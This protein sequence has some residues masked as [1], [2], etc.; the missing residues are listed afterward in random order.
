[1][2]EEVGPDDAV[3]DDGGALEGGHAPQEEGALHEPVHGDPPDEGVGEELSDGE[4]GEDDPV[5]QPLRVVRLGAR[6]QGL[7]RPGREQGGER[8]F[9]SSMDAS[10]FFICRPRHSGVKL[11]F[12]QSLNRCKWL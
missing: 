7:D 3:V 2:L 6:L 1:M 12:N 11:G 10:I 8:E 5:H 4:D 9:Q